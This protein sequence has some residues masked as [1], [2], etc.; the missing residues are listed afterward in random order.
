MT[1][2]QSVTIVGAGPA[3]LTC[4]LLLVQAGVPVTVMERA[5]GL[6]EDMRATTFHPATLDQLEGTGVIGTLLAQGTR[7]PRWQLLR[8]HDGARVVFD[9]SVLEGD[10]KHP[11]RL[12]VEQFRLTT[13][14]VERLRDEPLFRLRRGA[15]VTKVEQ[16]GEFVDYQFEERGEVRRERCR[17]LIAADGA[18]SLVRQSLGVA[19]EGSD[20]PVTSV[21]LVL[22]YPFEE[23]FDHLLGVNHIWTADAYYELI[24]VRDLWRFSF[25]PRDEANPTEIRDPESAQARLQAVFPRDEPYRIREVNHYSLQ[26]RCLERFRVGRVL[27]CGDSAHLNSPSGGLGM[28]SGIHDAGC[29][30]EHLAAV[31]EGADAELLDRYDRRRRTIAVED[32]QRLS[33]RG[34]RRQEE[35]DPARRAAIWAEF[36]AIAA[37]PVLH[38]A[39]LLE[40]SMLRSRQRE[41]EIG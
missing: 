28:N 37:D 10:T 31:L 11:Y 15:R 41:G 33:A 23:A 14:I 32:I 21:S 30:V 38:R 3:G 5:P 24:R 39:F 8:Q 34:Q 7:V 19:F 26:Q 6:P 35:T 40:T 18:H 2:P 1:A 13:A 12:Q 20:L 9:L 29:L 16:D 25:S 36:E 27:F 17:W 4:A 22:D